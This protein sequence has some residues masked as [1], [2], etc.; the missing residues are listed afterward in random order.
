MNKQRKRGVAITS[1]GQVLI[2]QKRR[3]KGY[4]PEKLAK[5]AEIGID[6]LRALQSGENKD[7]KTIEAVSNA[8]GIQPID[9]VDPNEWYP[10]SK[11]KV[12]DESNIYSVKICHQMLKKQQEQ[13]NNRRK[14]SSMGYEVDVHVPLGLVERKQQQRRN[15]NVEKEDI[16]K[17]ESEVITK[18][19]QHDEFLQEIIN[20]SEHR[21]SKHIAIVGEPGA[22]KTTLLNAIA[23]YIKDKTQ[24][25]PIFISL[26]SL[27]GMTLTDY[28][29]KKWLPDAARLVNVNAVINA[30]VEEEFKSEFYQGKFWLLLD[31]VDEMGESSPIQALHKIAQEL[32][33]WLG[34]AKVILTCRLNVWDATTNNNILP[35]FTTFKTQEFTPEDVEKFI[36]DWFAKANKINHGEKLILQLQQEG[37]KRIRELVTNPLRLSLLCQIFDQDENGELPET[38][39]QFYQ[40][41]TR[42]FYE[43]KPELFPDL[44]T[45]YELR[46]KL[47]QGLGNLA[48][49]GINSDV[50]FRLKRSFAVKAMGDERLFNLACEVG[51]LNQVDRDA[52]SDEDVYAF[53]HP[54]FQEYF[55]ALVIDDWRYFLNHVSDNP[56]E[57]IY[58]VFEAKWKEVILLWFGNKYGG[59]AYQDQKEEFIKALF[60]FQD[61]CD[62]FY[63][64]QSI[65][66]ASHIITEYKE[67]SLAEAIVWLISSWAIGDFNEQEQKW[68]DFPLYIQNFA[69]KAL[70][71][72]NSNLAVEFLEIFIEYKIG[73]TGK[74]NLR[75]LECLGLIQ[76]GHYYAI[77]KLIY[78]LKNSKNWSIRQE[79]ARILGDIAFGNLEAKNALLEVIHT[80]TGDLLASIPDFKVDSEPDSIAKLR[81]GLERSKILNNKSE[82]DFRASESL[83]KIDPGNPQAIKTLINMSC[84]YISAKCTYENAIFLLKSIGL[85]Q[86][87]AI[88]EL[89]N[90]LNSN[91]EAVRGA[92]AEIFAKVEPNNQEV[93]DILIELLC[94][95]S[96]VI[97][98]VEDLLTG[99]KTS[100]IL[101]DY[102]HYAEYALISVGVDNLIIINKLIDLLYSVKKGE[103]IV[104]ITNILA[105]IG[106]GNPEV[107][108]ALTN[109]LKNNPDEKFSR[110][111]AENLG[112]ADP[113]NKEAIDTLLNL[114]NNSE[115]A[116]DCITVMWSLEK[117]GVGND[118]AIESVANLLLNFQD[119]KIWE[120]AF[121][122]LEK[123]AVNTRNKIA[124]NVLTKLLDNY[125]D[126]SIM[127]TVADLLLII[128]PGNERATEVLSKWFPPNMQLGFSKKL[129]EILNLDKIPNKIFDSTKYRKES[130]EYIWHCAQNMTYPEFYH[131]WHGNTPTIQTLENQLKNTH[132]LLTQLQPT[133]KTYP[134]PLNLQ[135]LQN[136]TEIIDIS[137]EICNQI[138]L[139][140]FT[141]PE[142]IPTV[143]N[144]PQLK[145]KIPQ[146]KKHLKTENLA[147]IIN[148]C[149]PNET[150]INFLN[151]LT[152]VLH[153]AFITEQPLNPPLRGFPQQQNLL[154][155]IQ[156]WICEIE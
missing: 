148:N 117:I 52:V 102:R 69:R 82:L 145:S 89:R 83:Y 99:N 29:I 120:R 43:W 111:I 68:Q 84:W 128:D 35:G 88:V 123:I 113:G 30:E 116:T 2:E 92:A 153:I 44:I 115:N 10:Q 15:E 6:T 75:D 4:T 65:I 54:N 17:L 71:K 135:T 40:L 74:I 138:Y 98:V 154:N 73:E 104:K 55:A 49:A 26:G 9:I 22:G 27:Q 96:P 118:K 57:G 85:R 19:Y 119:I 122:T 67:C 141:E 146:I 112:I 77:N 48:L 42:Y 66:L 63:W 14:A 8:L 127:Y 59:K 76:P 134:L 41:F 130:Q 32:T 136:E 31:G 94:N 16:Y 37:K 152:D 50:R 95:G 5:V 149:E 13:Q 107:I 97:G 36:R 143:N 81:Q 51:W 151:K 23:T 109:A 18:T 12:K 79:A 60:D 147:L 126:E 34:Q 103:N 21:K 56:D 62:N 1:E 53:F 46:E 131:A 142:E 7:K 91:N 86:P 72:T 150:I 39:A 156:N 132:S 144:A 45:S 70:L 124:V 25:L 139:T 64:Y 90:E 38:K 121:S 11:N 61:N 33:N 20:K 129:W 78:L 28:V 80:N 155:T 101:E 140:A 137:Q 47:H 87:E 125:K 133:N 114:V 100:E 24:D 110:E 93:I 105:Q 106:T 108:S 58:R 3:E